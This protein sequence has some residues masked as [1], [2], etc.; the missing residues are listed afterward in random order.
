MNYL[1]ILRYYLLALVKSGYFMQ[2]PK[3]R[4]SKSRRNMRRAHDALTPLWL[5]TC[6]QC[7]E[8]VKSHSICLSCGYY[9]G[10]LIIP[11]LNEAKK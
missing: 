7:G 11:G 8:S 10:K 1:K 3:K 4:T 9:G 5:N 2:A 6:P